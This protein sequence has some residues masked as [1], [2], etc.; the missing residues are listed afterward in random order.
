MGGRRSATHEPRHT[1][2][3]TP[4]G[5]EL[6]T[7]ATSRLYDQRVIRGV[8]GALTVLVVA[9][10]A[11]GPVR[12][13]SADAPASQPLPVTV[14]LPVAAAST[15]GRVVRL[16]AT[17]VATT[18]DGAHVPVPGATVTFRATT[19]Q[20]W[21]D[22]G[23][24]TTGSAGHAWLAVRPNAGWHS[25]RAVVAATPAD[26]A[27]TGPLGPGTAPGASVIGTMRVGK[28][29]LQLR[30]T[31]RTI[32]SEASTTVTVRL[33]S[34]TLPPS[35]LAHRRVRVASKDWERPSFTGA[36]WLTTDG[37]ADLSLPVRTWHG[38]TLR[39]SVP[40]Q[41]NTAAVVRLVRVSTRPRL[42]S[43]SQAP[44]PQQQF[45]AGAAPQGTGAHII[46]G[47]VPDGVWRRMV[48]VSW[49]RGCPVGRT[50]LRYVQL[51]YWGFDGYRHR[52]AIIV[53]K[54]IVADTEGAFRALYDL[55]FRIRQIRPEDAW[56]RNPKGL[57]ADD[58]AAMR[59][60][61]TDGFN[62]RYVDGRESQHVL[63][64]HAYGMA[65]DLNTFENPYVAATG[66]FP[67]TYW[68][69]H[70]QGVG[71]LSRGSAAA[72]AFTSR[73]FFWG[74]NWSAPDFQHFQQ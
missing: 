3:D 15:Y 23:H 32:T 1:H 35:A 14:T 33:R 55:R 60:D 13:A 52:G 58:Y 30:T 57:G 17:V 68:R 46:A 16:T 34:A 38:V 24:A 29:A 37:G 63:S 56:G 65:I 66:T 67:D 54:Q 64:P 71:V 47:P 28:A 9:L 26:P 74:A 22:I 2:R 4:A 48:G 7:P 61:D 44:H 51:N 70:R 11:L 43:V 69:T 62:C 8:L 73:G 41:A 31:G 20:Q 10:G 25:F 12:S 27:S 45:P 36:H 39:F 18:T 21:H 49:S 42:P 6:L 59:S 53:N 5:T 40:A 19:D 50:T 72:R